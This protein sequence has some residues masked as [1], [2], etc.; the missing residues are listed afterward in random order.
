ME[1]SPNVTVVVRDQE[2]LVALRGMDD[3]DSLT[4]I[5]AASADPR[6]WRELG[7]SWLRYR[8]DEPWEALAWDDVDPAEVGE[9][10]LLLDLA[11]LRLV[12]D[13]SDL[14]PAERGGYQEFEGTWTP[15]M[16][17]VRFNLPPDWEVATEESLED[18]LLP[19]PIPSEPLDFRGVLFGRALTDFFARRMLALVADGS[20]PVE[21]VSRE[22]MSQDPSE[23]EVQL[24]DASHWYDLTVCLHAEWLLTPRADLDGQTPR[25]F[26]HR[27]RAWV[28][29]E[30]EGRVTQWS[31]TKRPP[32]AL[33]RDTHAYRYGPMGITEVVIYF[34]TCRKLLED[35]WSKITAH[36]RK[37][38]RYPDP[39]EFREELWRSL[40]VWLKEGSIDGMVTSPATLIDSS[41]CH[42]PHL[43][44][45]FELDC[46]CPLC[47]MALEQAEEFGPTFSCF[48]GYHLELDDE[49]AF[50]LCETREEWEENQVC[51]RGGTE[52]DD[53]SSD[54]MGDRD[55][56]PLRG[57]RTG[58]MSEL[59]SGDSLEDDCS[60]DDSSEDDENEFKS[61]WSGYI[62]D[63]FRGSLRR[64]GPA[65]SS[66]LGLIGL[67]FR[68]T[69]LVGD[70]RRS[71]TPGRHWD[72]INHAF[73]DLRRV[74]A[75][76]DARSRRTAAND[77]KEELELL[78]EPFPALIGKIA[79]L[80]SQVDAW[81]RQGCSELDVL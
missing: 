28:E 17:T 39:E 22:E 26:L 81:S 32:R 33:D 49:F 13:D 51:L 45:P 65:G 57:D 46:E 73:D 41:R 3:W 64:S 60:E 9:R 62:A 6:S 19:L 8:P 48:D 76:G 74:A 63:D 44:E 10:W 12:S 80:Q 78:C 37:S 16:R 31:H 11:R 50:S 68:L 25:E 20:A 23:R 70:L 5:A 29:A 4:I 30:T 38:G 55:A 2:R 14:I 59:E 47:R 77:L 52:I 53:E 36:R 72:G 1:S 40:Q 34:D 43:A 75:T 24:Q 79:D 67:G 18:A 69:E 35:G 54:G 61:P 15:E 21:F 56:K 71:R 7:Y 58:E 27:G 42:M 66:G